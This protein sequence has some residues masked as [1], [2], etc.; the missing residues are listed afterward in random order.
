[1]ILH[2]ETRLC[3]PPMVLAGVRAL[4]TSPLLVVFLEQLFA[5]SVPGH[6]RF[7]HGGA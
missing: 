7:Y 2:V 1:M 3:C 6:Y 5:A 4:P